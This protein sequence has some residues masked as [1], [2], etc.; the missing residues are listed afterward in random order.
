M[1]FIPE[2]I[3]LSEQQ[4][5]DLNEIAQSRSPIS[6]WKQRFVDQT[7][8]GLDTYHRGQQAVVLTPALRAKILADVPLQ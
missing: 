3:K 6:R 5:I 8:E 1:P 2:P 4:R 7:L